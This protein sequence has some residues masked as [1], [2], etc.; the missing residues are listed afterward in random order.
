MTD[1]IGTGSW[2]A[3]F[4]I[5]SHFIDFLRMILA[6]WILLFFSQIISILT[7]FLRQSIFWSANEE[8]I[9][10]FFSSPTKMIIFF[11]ESIN[12][13]NFKNI[14][15]RLHSN[16]FFLYSWT[17]K[18]PFSYDQIGDSFSSLKIKF[19]FFEMVWEKHLYS[20]HQL[21]GASTFLPIV[22]SLFS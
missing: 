3:H 10:L 5:T 9:L 7:E 17:R 20:K 8:N 4:D 21:C 13:N 14:F 15:F 18:I 12:P 19:S 6:H 16:F 1:S 11:P 2:L 22:N